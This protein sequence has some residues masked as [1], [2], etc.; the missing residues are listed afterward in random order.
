[1]KPIS[2]MTV[3]DTTA[4]SPPVVESFRGRLA[5]HRVMKMARDEKLR[6]DINQGYE[7]AKQKDKETHTHP[8]KAWELRFAGCF[9]GDCAIVPQ[10]V[11]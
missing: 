1:M 5:N 7:K 6:N 2:A 9:T 10:S 4:R 11:I 3:A 8:R